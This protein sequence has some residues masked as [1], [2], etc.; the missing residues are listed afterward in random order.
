MSNIPMIDLIFAGFILLMVI[1]G[2]V[3]GFVE[4]FFAWA[5]MILAIWAAVLLYPA[6]AVFI[7]SKILHNVRYVPEILSF[8][9]IFIIVM[10][11]VKLVEFILKDVI[12]GTKLR[13]V[14]KIL[15][16]LFGLVEGITLTALVVFVLSVQPVF[17][18]EKLLSESFFAQLLI[19]LIKIPLLHHGK[20]AVA[21]ALSVL[22]GI[23]LPL[24]P[25]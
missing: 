11:I 17:K 18:I 9:A 10:I 12:D 1:H 13:G 21:A 22:A 2:F 24:F 7:R 14:D 19:P 20:G 8:I 3:K 6:G 23:R 5:A 16:L 25:A 4:E 15:G